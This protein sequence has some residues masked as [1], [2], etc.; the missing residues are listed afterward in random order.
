MHSRD[1]GGTQ[2]ARFT[3]GAHESPQDW[4][5]LLLDLKR[6]GL[7]GARTG[8]CGR[9]LKAAGEI[10]P[11]RASSGLGAQSRE[12]AR[13]PAEEPTAV[14]KTGLQEIWMTETKADAE[15]A[16]EAVIESYQTKY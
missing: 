14:G 11:Q 15:A 12:R 6:H 10:W 2:T 5:V 7:S 13:Q 8:D 9:Q 3:E 16:F 4:R 1:A